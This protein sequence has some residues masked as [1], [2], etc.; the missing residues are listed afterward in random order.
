MIDSRFLRACMLQLLDEQPSYGYEVMARLR[1]QGWKSLE[2][3]RGYR[4]LRA[5]EA[6]GLLRSEWCDSS[7]GP[8]RRAYS[9]T[10]LT[11]RTMRGKEP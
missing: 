6:E 3:G 11:A 1:A 9:L 8:R 5:L 4:V 10:S 2:T 7:Q